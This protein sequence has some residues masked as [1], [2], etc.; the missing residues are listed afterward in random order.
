MFTANRHKTGNGVSIHL[1]PFA[2]RDISS[3][4]RILL[5]KKTQHYIHKYQF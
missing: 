2:Y 4:K 3:I 5:Y 1:V